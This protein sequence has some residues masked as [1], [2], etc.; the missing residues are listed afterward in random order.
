MWVIFLLSAMAIALCLLMI[1]YIGNKIFIK[2]NNDWK[3]N[4]N[5]KGENKNE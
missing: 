1:V 5:R 3:E 2:M 4:E